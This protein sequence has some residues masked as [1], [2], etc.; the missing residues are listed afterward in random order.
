M[1]GRPYLIEAVPWGAWLL[2]VLLG[3]IAYWPGLTGSYL[4][5]DWKNLELMSSAGKIRDWQG[6]VTYL[7]SGFASFTG[8]PVAML[9]F[10]V[11]AGQWPVPPSLLKQHNI[12]LHLVNGTLLFLL[13][14]TLLP[15]GGMDRKRA[16]WVALVAAALWMLHPL[17]VSTTLYV[18]QRMAMLA[19]TFV[20]LAL[21]AYT[22]GRLALQG[23]RD[24]AAKGWLWFGVGVFGL[25]GVLSKENAALLPLF[26]L[27]LEKTVLREWAWPDQC[28]WARWWRWFFVRLPLVV[29]ALYLAARV[30]DLFQGTTMRGGYTPA[31]RF[32]TQGG[33]RQRSVS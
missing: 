14:R 5:D 4:F 24:G 33:T 29:V 23:G 15:M 6:V 16:R 11:D 7:L 28:R 30:P 19:T 18:V 25:L 12:Y 26:I 31:E 3:G 17:L 8:R 27:V 10:L 21:Y 20:L 9:S 22:R 1:K 32:L 13:L 2:V